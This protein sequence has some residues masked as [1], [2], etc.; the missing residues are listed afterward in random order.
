M[1]I[2]PKRGAGRLLMPRN[3]DEEFRESMQVAFTWAKLH[4][5]GG[6]VSLHLLVSAVD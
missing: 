6:L 2:R 3:V 1:H 5:P 4:E